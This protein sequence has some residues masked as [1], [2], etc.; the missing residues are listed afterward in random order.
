MVDWYIRVKF[1]FSFMVVGHLDDFISTLL[2]ARSAHELIW[3]HTR[4]QIKISSDKVDDIFGKY[5]F[6]N[7]DVEAV[8]KGYMNVGKKNTFCDLCGLL[9]GS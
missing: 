7:K 9:I 1:I 3:T 5:V 6:S 2:E 4:T 8:I